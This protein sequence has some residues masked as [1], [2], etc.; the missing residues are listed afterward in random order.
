MMTERAWSFGSDPAGLTNRHDHYKGRAR[1]FTRPSPACRPAA[2]HLG[3][4]LTGPLGVGAAHDGMFVLCWRL[5]R[6]VCS[7]QFRRAVSG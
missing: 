6:S 3:W 1:T 2:H 5:V 7:V 4:T